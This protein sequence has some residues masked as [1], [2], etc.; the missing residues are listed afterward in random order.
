MQTFLPFPNFEDSAAC[1]DRQRLGKQRV[2][3]VQIL[4]VLHEVTTSGWV[5]HPA[6]KMWR[7]YEPQLAEYGLA[8]CEEW[9]KR[10]YLDNKCGLKIAWHLECATSGDFTMNKPPWFGNIDFHLSHQSNL[11]RKDPEHYGKY[12]PGVPDDLPYVWPVQ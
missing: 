9:V 3:V 7:G 2:E 4:N 5:N 1:L 12:F 10:G 6:V 11:L 8:V